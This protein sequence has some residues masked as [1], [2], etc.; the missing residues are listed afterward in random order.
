MEC[1]SCDGKLHVDTSNWIKW[2]GIGQTVSLMLE[3]PG[4]PGGRF[5]SLKL[6][7]YLKTVEFIKRHREDDDTLVPALVPET[8]DGSSQLSEVYVKY[9]LHSFQ[10][11]LPICKTLLLHFC[12]VV[13]NIC[14]HIELENISKTV[15]FSRFLVKWHTFVFDMNTLQEALKYEE[16]R[17]RLSFCSC[18]LCSPWRWSYFSHIDFSRTQDLGRRRKKQVKRS[19]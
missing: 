1:Y 5:S 16:S 13:Y 8:L 3:D 4:R 9:I 7:W 15:L 6:K 19:D 17:K 18:S 11:A 10:E 14:I 2:Q 12:V